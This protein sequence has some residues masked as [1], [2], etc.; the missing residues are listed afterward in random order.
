MTRGIVN[1]VLPSLSPSLPPSFQV[2]ALIIPFLLAFLPE[3]LSQGI[4]HA[5]AALQNTAAFDLTGHPALSVNAGVSAPSSSSPGRVGKKGGGGLPIGVQV[6][7]R[8]WEDATVLN[9]G[10]AIELGSG[11][12]SLQSGGLK[13]EGVRV[14]PE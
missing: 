7:G 11:L 8:R 14:P 2:L 13:R 10:R 5:W 4:S 3:P 9:V 1:S 12:T 6:V